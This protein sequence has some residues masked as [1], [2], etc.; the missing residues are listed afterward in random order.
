[1]TKERKIKDLTEK[2]LA[3]LIQQSTGNHIEVNGVLVSS[4]KSNLKEV[5]ACVNRLLVK[6]KDYLSFKRELKLKTGFQD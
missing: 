6:H 4:Q 1:M 2:E 3:E 5:E